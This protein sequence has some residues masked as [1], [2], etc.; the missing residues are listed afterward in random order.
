MFFSQSIPASTL[1]GGESTGKQI[2]YQDYTC[3]P[4]M[5]HGAGT[6]KIM[7][8]WAVVQIPNLQMGKLRL[9]AG[10]WLVRHR[11]VSWP[12][13]DSAKTVYVPSMARH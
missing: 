10:K 2:H 6:Q 7:V 4:S 12:V 5:Q 13:N 11:A 1:G 3:I 8:G 9:R